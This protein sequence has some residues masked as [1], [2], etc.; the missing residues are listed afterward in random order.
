MFKGYTIN[1]P[2]LP[3]ETVRKNKKVE[4]LNA[5]IACDTETS[6]NHENEKQFKAC[7]IYQWAFTFNGSLYYGRTPEQLC[8]KLEEIVKFYELNDTKRLKVYFHNLP[9]DFSYLS[10]YFTEFFGDPTKVLATSPHKLFYAEYSNGLVLLCSYKLSNDSLLRW[11][12]KLN[13]K[14]K[15]LSELGSTIYNKVHNQYTPLSYTDWRYMFYDVIV[16]DECIQAQ[17][18]LYDDTIAS[19]PL[20]STGYIRRELRRHFERGNYHQRKAVKTNKENTGNRADFLRSRLDL[21]S[22]T[23]IYRNFSGGYTHGNRFYQAKTLYGRIKHR[24]FTSHYPTQIRTRHFPVGKLF[25]LTGQTTIQELERYKDDYFIMCNVVCQNMILKDNISFPYLQEC[26]A[27][28]E[29]TQNTTCLSDNGRVVELKG[30][31]HLYLHYDEL[32]LILKQ[33]HCK[34]CIIETYASKLDYLPDWATEC[35]DMFFGGKT[36]FKQLLKE[37]EAQEAHYLKIHEAEQNL[38][39]S[40]NGL[41]GIYGCFAT[42]PCKEDFT[43]TN[44]NEWKCEKVTV[45]NIESKLN[46]F[47]S[48]RAS[49][50]SY[51]FGVAVTIYARMQLYEVMEIINSVNIT[52]NNIT[53]F[54]DYGN[55]EHYNYNKGNVI[56]CDTDSAFYF[57]NDEIEQKIEA[58]NKKCIASALEHGAYIIDRKGNKV[59][60][61]EFTDENENIHAFRFLHSKCYAYMDGKK[62]KCTVAGVARLSSDHKTT[63]EQELHCIKNLKDDFTF[64]KCGGT[65]SIYLNEQIHMYNG[66]ST[67]GGC[68]ISDTTKT[69]TDKLF[70]DKLEIWGRVE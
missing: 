65:T 20:T 28:A 18:L 10:V 50:M 66:N 33:Y 63:R 19:I 43:L 29:I 23:Y 27:M 12:K 22:Y 15:K 51:Q 54:D 35:T 67:A 8:Y 14:H 52:D 26:H 7:W 62:L 40:K 64:I 13:T 9:Y 1:A 16:L 31:T 6:H 58:Y 39:K 60:Y 44:G 59:H 57:T 56:Y 3:I 25:K 42:N 45:N 11:S 38:M 4:F 5:Y 69:I 30:L 24:D 55:K 2:F 47:Y 37:L 46:K 36:T 48:S 21:K 49:F 70:T 53:I 17:M 34:Y 68:V 61:N 32:Q 41:N